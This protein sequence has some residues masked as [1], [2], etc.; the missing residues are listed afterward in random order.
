M[1]GDRVWWVDKVNR[2]VIYVVAAIA[3]W[4][5]TY[6]AGIH[7]VRVDYSTYRYSTGSN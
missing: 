7:S 2:F 5:T 1:N 4:S 6:W 3:I